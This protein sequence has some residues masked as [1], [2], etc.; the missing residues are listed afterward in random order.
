MTTIYDT[1]IVLKG[2]NLANE[3]AK[4]E[5]QSSTVYLSDIRLKHFLYG[6]GI[7]MVIHF[8]TNFLQHIFNKS[9]FLFQK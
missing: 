5:A 8:E 4:H 1:V 3:I 6:Y 2:M 7:L 9:D